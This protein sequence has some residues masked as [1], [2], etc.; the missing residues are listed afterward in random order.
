MNILITVATYFPKKD[1]VQKVTQYLAEGLVKKGHK[2]TVITTNKGVNNR[3]EIIN[4][5][6]VKRVNL[7]TKFG[8][9]IGDKKDYK[10]MI[11]EETQKCDVMINV[12]TQ[13]AFT[14]V[15]LKNIDNYKCKKILYLHGIFDF[16]FSKVNFTSLT[17]VVNKLW[18][19][20]RWSLYYNFNG[21]YFKKYD[22]V[23]QLHE[24][25]Y[26]NIYFKKKYGINSIIIENAADEEFFEKKTFPEFIK[27]FDKYIIFV[28]NYDDRKNQKLAIKEFLN[29]KIDD[30]IG[31]VLIGSC[32]NKYYDKLTKYIKKEKTKLKI[33]GTNKPIKMLYNIDRSLVSSYVSNAYLYLMTSKWEA[34]PIS[35][36]E[37]M[38]SGVPFIST[39]VGVAKYLLGGIVVNNYDKKDIHYFIEKICLNEELRNDIGLLGNRIA[40]CNMKIKD[41]V[42][43]LERICNEKNNI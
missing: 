5:V 14:D 12:C 35:L 26:G 4:G 39:D 17:S 19:E 15:I 20:I 33:S 28:A 6:I 7:F 8:F 16:K 42:D 2:V 40:L 13:N 41:K 22:A 30:N 9:Y 3:E 1:G 38:A 32:K 10:K 18:K 29:S 21:K 31:L 25:D 37:S 27:P 11:L 34:Y 36:I 43:L 24:K 23:T